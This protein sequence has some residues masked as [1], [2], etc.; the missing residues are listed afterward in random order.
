MPRLLTIVL[1]LEI[2]LLAAAAIVHAGFVLP[3]HEH[4]QAATAEVVI[5]SVLLIGLVLAAAWPK[6][7]RALALG[8]QTFALIG[9]T[10]VL[11]TILVGAGPQSG[12]DLVFH[13]LLLVLLV[14]GA[15]WTSRRLTSGNAAP[16][17]EGESSS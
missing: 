12:A 4:V 1:A 2:L 14:F 9:T 13:G 6:R 3:G 5:G 8:T 17:I 11:F 15:V 7:R 10:V 16:L